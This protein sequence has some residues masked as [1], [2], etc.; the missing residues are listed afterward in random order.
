MGLFSKTTEKV[1]LNEDNPQ[2]YRDRISGY[3]GFAI[4]RSEYI[5]GCVRV[6]LSSK[7]KESHEEPKEV[8]FDEQ[9]LVHIGSLLNGTEPEETKVTGNGRTGGP[10]PA[11]KRSGH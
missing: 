1:V 9:Q 4:A 2:L 7:V 3:E 8:W 10:R 11:P 5:N 6:G